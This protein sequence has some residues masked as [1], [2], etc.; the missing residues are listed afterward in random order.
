MIKG[1]CRFSGMFIFACTVANS[2]SNCFGLGFGTVVR[3][4]GTVISTCCLYLG[5]AGGDGV[6]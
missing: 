4:A 6:R 2:R 3:G 5:V 1:L